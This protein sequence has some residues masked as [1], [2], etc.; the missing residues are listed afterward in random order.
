MI[1]PKQTLKKPPAEKS[2][3]SF[4]LSLYLAEIVAAMVFSVFLILSG[5]DILTSFLVIVTFFSLLLLPIIIFFLHKGLIEIL[6]YFN[7]RSK[8]Q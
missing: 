4:I 8:E 7:G 1:E 5:K 3:A 6:K 2:R